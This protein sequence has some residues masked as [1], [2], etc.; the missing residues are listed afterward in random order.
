MWYTF[1]V[2]GRTS[3]TLRHLLKPA[4]ITKIS[5]Q[6]QELKAQ[7]ETFKAEIEGKNRRLTQWH[8]KLQKKSKGYRFESN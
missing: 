8:A 3:K 7:D 2:L 6:L 5:R 1:N 4:K